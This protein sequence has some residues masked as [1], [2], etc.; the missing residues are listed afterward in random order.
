[1]MVKLHLIT[2]FDIS[3]FRTGLYLTV[4]TYNIYIYLH[5]STLQKS[6]PNEASPQREN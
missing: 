1:M 2:V 6:F 5:Y 3:F 4:F